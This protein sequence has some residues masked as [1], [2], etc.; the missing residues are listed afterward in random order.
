MKAEGRTILFVT[1]DMNAV[2]RFCDRAMLLERGAMVDIGDPREIGRR[3][4]E[5][6][7]NR[8]DLTRPGEMRIG[9]AEEAEIVSLTIEQPDGAPVSTVESG[10][11]VS[12]ALE[13]WT[14]HELVNPLV[15][16]SLTDEDGRIV[17]APS[18]EVS[19]GMPERLEAG[20]RYVL[21]LQFACLLAPGRY[22]ITPALARIGREGDIV[23][24]R[25][26]FASFWVLSTRPIA[27]IADLPHSF[28]TDVA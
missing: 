6:N 10:S 24:L 17:F 22:T 27:G 11:T 28:R 4:N 18:S 13:I 5:L 15:S 26:A 21:R 25:D 7:F 1:H 19:E 23:D 16:F 20:R 9:N 3:Y 14:R 12:F 8:G 2:D